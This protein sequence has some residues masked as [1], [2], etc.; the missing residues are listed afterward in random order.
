MLKHTN[1]ASQAPRNSSPFEWEDPYCFAINKQAPRTLADDKAARISL[2]GEWKF[3]WARKPADRP[4]H[5]Y[6]ADFDARHWGNITVPGLWQLQ[7]FDVP[8]YLAA[9]YP[10]AISTS[11]FR[12][13]HINHKDNPVGSYLHEFEVPQSWL[14]NGKV[15]LHFGAVKSAFYLWLNGNFVGYSQG[16]MTPAEFDVSTFLHAGN[17]TMAVEVYRYSDGTYLEDQ[18]M[19]FLSGI[20]RDVYIYHEPDSCI[21]DFFA[22]CEFINNYADA[23][24]LLDLT[25]ENN[26]AVQI[27]G[28]AVWKLSNEQGIYLEGKQDYTLESN[29][30]KNISFKQVASKPEKWNAESP[31]LYT[32]TIELYENGK[33]FTQ[34]SCRFGF[35]QVEIKNEKLLINGQAVL[36]KG[37]NRH[38]FDPDTGWVLSDER[39][40][41]DLRILKQ[42]NINA[43]RTAH[44]PND[45]RFYEL[46]D[47]YGIY[48]MDEVDVET[49]GVRS[50]NCPGNHPQWREALCDRGERMVQRDKNHAC[51]IMWSLGNESAAGSNFKAMRNSMLAIDTTR[52]IHYE[53]DDEKGE[54]SDVLSFMYP[55]QQLLDNLGQHRNHVRPFYERIAGKLGLFNAANL[56][57]DAY[58]GK[59]VILCEYAHCMMNSL[60]NF[61]EFIERFEKYDNFCGGFI[62][63]YSDQA[64]RKY[65][66]INGEKQERWLYGGD[67][68]ESKSDFSF[69]A[70]GLVTANR[71]LQPAM[72]EVKKGYQYIKSKLIDFKQ[73]AVEVS[74]HYTFQTIEGHSLVWEIRANGIN[75]ATGNIKLPS[76]SP[77][78][79]SPV[80][81][82]FNKETLDSLN[83]YPNQ[84]IVLH[85]RYIDTHQSQW[86][87]GNFECAWEEFLIKAYVPE[88]KINKDN[89]ST[90]QNATHIYVSTAKGQIRFDKTLG[91]IDG[92]KY[93][94]G[95]LLTQA[96]RPN[97][98]RARTNND[99]ALAFMNKAAKVLYPRP[100][101]HAYKRMKLA[102]LSIEQS[103]NKIEISSQHKFYLSKDGFHGKT[104]IYGNGDIEFEF[105]MTP[106]LNLIRFGMQVHVKN[107]LDTFSWYGRG[108]MENYCDR[109]QGSALGFYSM[110]VNELVHHYL[111]PQ[112]NGNRCDIQFAS[113]SNDEN[114]GLYIECTDEQRL[115][116]STWP[117]SQDDL[118]KADHIH[119]LPERDFV[120]LNIDH[121]QQG[122]GGDIPGMLNLKAPYQLK[123]G[124]KLC[125][126]FR[127]SPLG[128]SLLRSSA[129]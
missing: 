77:G 14:E 24:F 56:Y 85:L 88:F 99:A 124:K 5:F 52:P 74:N 29:E 92:I 117:W 123:R 125:Y 16:S 50:K 87:E 66:T 55:P 118:D 28:T 95:E 13:P 43:V 75:I 2:N 90:K 23:N 113:L 71:K 96:M 49:H 32:L 20:Y 42:N 60:G 46:C 65:E 9:S 12:I 26:K 102:S 4:R 82:D 105:S 47:E 100:W 91:F 53:G 33:R 80:F 68:K 89:I 114:T 69:C 21:H 109:K 38:D 83:H 17:N 84:E 27:N 64:I 18:D 1:T 104:T 116:M 93:S 97:F 37:V 67:F 45:A 119:E 126:S 54:L 112:E 127:I 101:K 15:L 40:H 7:G 107:K 73:G 10:P 58:K 62:W 3:H 103:E 94:H 70:N 86:H 81:L 78:Q 11:R 22:R 79:S 76:I 63:D 98:D 35:R 8:Y 108:P 31:R 122:V 25:L 34:K 30:H 39:Y 115:S 106:R 129:L 128:S 6:K 48:V 61:D 19:W 120:V 72:F 121:K 44:Y 41:Q 51:I 57:V 59:P 110:K 36:L 111:R